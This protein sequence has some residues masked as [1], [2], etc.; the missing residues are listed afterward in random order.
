MRSTPR[1]VSRPSADVLSRGF[2]VPHV[3]DAGRPDVSS[4]PRGVRGVLAAVRALLVMSGGPVVAL[5]AML[6]S[7]VISVLAVL[8]GDIP[9]VPATLVLAAGGIYV[10]GVVP[11]TRRWGTRPEECDA[12]LPGDEYVAHA[13]L[14][15]TR[16]ITIDAPP[17]AVWGWLAQIGADRGG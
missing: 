1:S 9:P 6:A 17:D 3:Q 7:T 8:G 5:A 2:A 12:L 15:M 4:T 13:G 11:W 14:R 10:V 16:A